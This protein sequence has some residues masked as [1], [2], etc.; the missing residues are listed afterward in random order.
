MSTMDNNSHRRRATRLAVAVLL[1]TMVLSTAS[2]AVGV[3]ATGS[4]LVSPP[5]GVAADGIAATTPLPAWWLDRVNRIRAIGGVAPVSEDLALSDG[6]WYHARYMAE[7]NWIGHTE[8]PAWPYYRSE[9]A[10]AAA[11]SNLYLGIGGNAAIDGWMRAPFHAIGIIDPRLQTTG[12]GT[13]TTL[14]GRPAAALDVLRG[15]GTTTASFP[16]V[17]P[18]NDREMPYLTYPGN[19][20]PDPLA[21]TGWT[22]PTGAP[23]YAQF[24]TGAANPVITASRLSTGGQDLEH[25]V[26]SEFTYTNSDADLQALGR[27]ILG[28]RDAVAIM[29]RAPLLANHR[30]DVEITANGQQYS[31]SFYTSDRTDP[32]TVASLRGDSTRRVDV[33]LTATDAGSGVA[34]TQWALDT[35][36]TQVYDGTLHFEAL[37]LHTLHYWSMDGAG[38]I[39]DVRSLDFTVGTADPPPLVAVPE[40]LASTSRYSTA[41]KIARE[42]FDPAG[43][44][45]WPSVQHVIIASGEDRAAAD[46]LAASGLCW[47]YDAPLFLVGSTRVDGSV[48]KALQEIVAANGPVSVHVVGGPVSVPDARFNDI[49]TAVGGQATKERVLATGGRYDLA[50][51]IARAMRAK[52]PGEMPSVALVANGADPAKFFDALALSPIS[53]HTGAPILLVSAEKIPPATA[54]ILG[55]LDPA[56]VVVGGGPNTV[57][58]GV[59]GQLGA[60]RW[61]GRTRYATATD[62]ASKAI[63]L[64]WLRANNVAVAA[65]LPDALTGGSAVGLKG[66][67]LMITDGAKLS[68]ETDSWLRSHATAIEY[69]WI[70]GGERSLTGAVLDEVEDALD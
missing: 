33:T 53:A 3:V 25:R 19:E 27:S 44:A 41:V 16:L 45:S 24:G 26:L 5:N 47:A 38:N 42:S 55:E 61:S 49:R 69:C 9:G 34:S 36:G 23:I 35:G 43:N 4:A 70:L 50:A 18:G 37:G 46:P 30:Y 52:R 66:G 29:P 2:P 59:V 65:K 8:N 12:F 39:E 28:T 56:T 1:M 60:V 17:W 20:N 21:G 51:A 63:A 32:V 22:L 14:G 57:S 58:A 13:Y 40:R 67:V 68:D 10:T 15:R 62:I 54:K 64:G 48:T 11:N 31:W 6:C 7:N